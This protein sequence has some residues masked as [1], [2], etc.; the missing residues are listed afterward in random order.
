[1]VWL[2][3]LGMV[4]LVLVVCLGT[5]WWMESYTRHGEGID[6]PNV[7]GKLMSDAQFELKEMEL[8]A[9]VIDSVYNKKLA[10]GIVLDQTPGPGSRVK[11]GREIFLTVNAKTVPTLP[12]PNIINNCSAREA[13]AQLTALGLKIGPYEYVPGDKDWVLGVKCRGRN[14][15]YGDRVPTETP[16]TLVVGNNE[17]ERNE[18]EI[19][20]DDWSNPEDDTTEDE[21]VFEEEVY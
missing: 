2:N 5:L 8:D 13:E 7:K 11:A 19:V 14:V 18:N 3:L 17:I 16:I 21:E 12:L 4:M 6:V 20:Y 9:V 10:P 15:Y 1:M